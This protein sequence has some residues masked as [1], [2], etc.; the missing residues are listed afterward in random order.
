MPLLFNMR[1]GTC[2]IT[3]KRHVSKPKSD[4][5][6]CMQAVAREKTLGEYTVSC[7][8]CNFIFFTFVNGG[9]VASLRAFALLGKPM[10]LSD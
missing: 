10:F 7:Q 9:F 3:M 5:F 1:R 2:L 8:I 4:I 6:L